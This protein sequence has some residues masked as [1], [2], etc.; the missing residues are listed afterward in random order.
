[1][2]RRK[3]IKFITG[4]ILGGS[5]FLLLIPGVIYYASLFPAALIPGPF[6]GDSLLRII[7]SF[8]LFLVGAVFMIWSNVSLFITGKGGPTEGFGVEISPKT[9]VLVIVGPY[10]YTRNPM[11]FGAYTMY[12]ALTVFLNSYPAMIL[13]LL[14]FPV[15]IFYLKRSEEKR[16][17][18]DFGEDF[19]KYRERV[20]MLIPLPPK[21]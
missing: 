9:K 12:L 6:P 17:L 8:L 20:S 2:N 10:R 16:L 15:I 5:F 4:Y 11:V 13:V 7:I 14:F 1:M 21:K 18:K 3:C 19:L